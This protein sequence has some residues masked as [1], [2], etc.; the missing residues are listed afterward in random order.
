MHLAANIDSYFILAY[1]LK[2]RSGGRHTVSIKSV[3]VSIQHSPGTRKSNTGTV[4]ICVVISSWAVG[5]R[6]VRHFMESSGG[7]IL[8]MASRSESWKGAVV[9]RAVDD[10]VGGRDGVGQDVGFAVTVNV[11]AVVLGT[12]RC[13]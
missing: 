6:G 7:T 11:S 5:S 2:M 9:Q 1:D 13:G 8:S 4:S 10:L 3:G 12:S